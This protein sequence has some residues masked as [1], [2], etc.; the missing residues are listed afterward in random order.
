MDA[1]RMISD[2]FVR[3]E[4]AFTTFMLLLT[5]S[6]ACEDDIAMAGSF[7]NPRFLDRDIFGSAFTTFKIFLIDSGTCEDDFAEDGSSENTG[8][9]ERDV[10]IF[11][12]NCIL[13]LLFQAIYDICRLSSVC[14]QN[15]F[16]LS[17]LQ[18]LTVSLLLYCII[19][20]YFSSQ[21]PCVG[22]ARN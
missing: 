8:P 1:V 9:Q 20:Y 13:A 11:I 22:E 15:S 10:L 7:K 19:I 12:S 3:F 14:G 2:V 18:L 21:C 6:G 16:K 5:I 17:W 4:S